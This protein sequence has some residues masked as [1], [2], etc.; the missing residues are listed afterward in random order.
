[1]LR[2]HYSLT[3]L[4]I[5]R[6][7]SVANKRLHRAAVHHLVL[8][9]ADH[10]H[11]GSLS[12]SRCAFLHCRLRQIGYGDISSAQGTQVELGFNIAIIFMGTCAFGYITGTVSSI[13]AYGNEATTIINRK[14]REINAYMK[15]RRLS[16]ELQVCRVCGPHT[17]KC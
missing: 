17:A 3:F 12:A 5:A 7:H 9:G 6:R 14:M 2:A 1:M 10:A 4:L 16:H 15:S 8:L 13:M 11:D